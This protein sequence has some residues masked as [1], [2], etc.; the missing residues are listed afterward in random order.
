MLKQTRTHFGAI[1]LLSVCYLPMSYAGSTPKAIENLDLTKFAGTWYEIARLPNKY[2]RD[3]VDV[4]ST[5]KIKNGEMK[6]INRGSERRSNKR[7]KILA[8]DVSLPDRNTP[9]RMKVKVFPFVSFEYK[10]IDIDTENYQWAIIT[11]DSR[12]FLWL[13][14]RNP[15]ISHSLYMNLVE[16]A[17]SMGFAVNK[18]E[19]VSQFSNSAVV[20]K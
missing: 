7:K 9:G 3:L 13:F 14:A 8:G 11:S 5:L 10:V 12:E 17:R 6:L 16:R 20:E 4:T 1:L 15:E 19:R 2:E 18:L